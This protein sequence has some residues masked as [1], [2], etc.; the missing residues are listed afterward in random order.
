MSS[1]HKAPPSVGI[2][3]LNYNNAQLTIDCVDSILKQDYLNYKIVVVD[4]NSP[5]ANQKLILQNKLPKEVV[6]V[7]N[8]KNTGYAAGNNVG[9]RFCVEELKSDFVFVLNNDTI[10]EDKET[11]QKLVE[12][13][14]E[15]NKIV[16]VSPLVN[17]TSAGKPVEQQI[18]VRKLLNKY[19]IIVCNVILTSKLPFF[20]HIIA[21][22]LY[23]NWRPYLKKTYE[24]DTINGSAFM[25][26]A[27]ALQKISYL[28][29]KTFLYSEELIL[30][31]QIQRIG[32]T[33]GLNGRV[34]VTH[35]QGLSTE[36]DNHNINW[37][38]HKYQIDSFVVLL[39]D[40][41]KTP[42]YLI[43]IFKILRVFDFIFKKMYLW[44]M[45][46]FG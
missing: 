12:T 29:E 18:Q 41:Y 9:A 45:R 7:L 1:S 35:F 6:L 34:V 3:V 27:D 25:I 24:V 39:K 15:N 40:Y 11:V 38:M 23:V 30:G 14:E 20:K 26:S 5:D 16:A 22:Y 28:N 42:Q 17:T 2:V 36:N 37:A 10:L 21:D 13:F 32:K 44:I 46:I 8:P 31:C 33:C 4:N 43:A 19:K